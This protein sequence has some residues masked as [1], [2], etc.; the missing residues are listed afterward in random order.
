M[1]FS[2]D[3][4]WCKNFAHFKGDNF[5]FSEG[6]SEIHD[7]NTMASCHHNILSNSTFAWWGAYLNRHEDKKIICPSKERWGSQIGLPAKWIQI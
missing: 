3:I 2:D 5:T 6:K 1:V 4:E 7:L